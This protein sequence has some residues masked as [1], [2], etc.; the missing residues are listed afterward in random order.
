[1][2]LTVAFIISAYIPQNLIF[3]DGCETVSISEAILQ[4]KVAIDENCPDYLNGYLALTDAIIDLIQNAKPSD[5]PGPLKK[6]WSV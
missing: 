1:M 6:V 2:Y 5:S 4:A 3:S